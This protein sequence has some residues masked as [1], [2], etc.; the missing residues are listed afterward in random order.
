MIHRCAGVKA[1]S[2]RSSNGSPCFRSRVIASSVPPAPCKDAGY[3]VII[4]PAQPEGTP[5]EEKP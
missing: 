5:F 3:C 2:P 4:V 1:M